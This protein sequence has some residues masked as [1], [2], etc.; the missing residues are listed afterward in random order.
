MS[1]VLLNL[2]FFFCYN[3]VRKEV[4]TLLHRY[5]SPSKKATIVKVASGV[6]D[7]CKNVSNSKR[8]LLFIVCCIT[9]C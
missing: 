6:D 3:S 1:T 5:L 8:S 2:I 7:W 9:I 4:K